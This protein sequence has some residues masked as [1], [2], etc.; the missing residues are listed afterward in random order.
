M[1]SR[2]RLVRGFSHDL[3]NPLGA[4][5]GH[6]ALLE[7]G[8][9]GDL[10]DTQRNS[11]Q[12]IR[13]ALAAAVSLINDLVEL[14]HAEAGQIALREQPVDVREIAREMVEQYRPAA[15]QAGLAITG[16]LRAVEIVPGDADR[17]RQ[18][19][20]NLLSNAVK[21]TKQGGQIEVKTAMRSADGRGECVAIDV[22]DTGIGVPQEKVQALFTEFER[23]DPS[24][25]PGA[26]LGLAI[27]RRLARLLGGEITVYTQRGR[28][29]TFTLWLPRSR[30]G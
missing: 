27:S 26:G 28:G 21:Y 18:I 17:V 14:A 12:R 29:S 20:G 9:L 4:A 5:D 11:V 13:V 10:T 3:K 6:A 24:V 16:E 1:E 22:V 7:D 8:V 15:Q 19:L 2:T 25:K 30:A 23:I